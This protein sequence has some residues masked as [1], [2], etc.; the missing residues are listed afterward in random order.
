VEIRD[1][2]LVFRAGAG[3][4]LLL[5]LVPFVSAAVDRATIPKSTDPDYADRPDA[6]ATLK[7]HIA[8]VAGDQNLRM[9]GTI[10]YI[11][12]ISNG[13]GTVTLQQIQD[14][15]LVI[16]SS[17]PL[18]KTSS[19]ITRARE[20]LRVQTEKFSEETKAQVVKNR[21]TNT[22]M[23]ASIRAIA[24]ESVSL[25]TN[26]TRGAL[27]LRNESAR[28]VLF[29]KESNDRKSILSELANRSI[30]T[31]VAKNI[32]EQIDSERSSLQ[33][34]LTNK[35]SRALQSTNIKIKDLNRQF[36]ENI[37]GIRAVMA[38]GMKRDAMMAMQ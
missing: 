34:A 7:N 26:S 16:A 18:M 37:A 15:Y 6:I 11:D 9:E 30:D 2:N 5:F 36:R 3:L 33:G 38:I 13:T 8:F 10:R 19:D 28:L 1:R 22:G 31:T 24:N 12:A 27:W 17:I 4:L 23:R 14:D 29:N 21:G 25:E 35:S 32:S 20:D